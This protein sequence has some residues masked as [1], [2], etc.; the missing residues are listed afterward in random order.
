MIKKISFFFHFLMEKQGLLVDKASAQIVAVRGP[1]FHVTTLSNVYVMNLLATTNTWRIG[2]LEDHPDKST[3]YCT[4]KLNKWVRSTFAPLED[5][6]WVQ[7]YLT[8]HTGSRSKLVGQYIFL[9]T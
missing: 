6:V 1:W 5:G 3:T 7:L 4:A 8:C 9:D 2:P